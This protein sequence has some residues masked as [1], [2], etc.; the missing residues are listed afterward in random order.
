MMLSDAFC[1]MRPGSIQSADKGRLMD[2]I[3]DAEYKVVEHQIAPPLD[4]CSRW[5]FQRLVRGTGSGLDDAS[6]ARR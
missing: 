5:R 3:P 6:Y 2:K 4:P 1:A